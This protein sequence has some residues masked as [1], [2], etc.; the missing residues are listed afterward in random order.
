MFL[1]SYRTFLL[2]SRFVCP[3]TV[4]ENTDITNT[5]YWLQI[6]HTAFKSLR[7]SSSVFLSMS[8][9]KLFA[10]TEIESQD[11]KSKMPVLSAVPRGS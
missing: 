11:R 6:A 2:K 8:Q 3:D 5:I 4:F 7:L 9:T 1:L 10:I